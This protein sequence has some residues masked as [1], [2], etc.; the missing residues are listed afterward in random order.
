MQEQACYEEVARLGGYGM[1][2]TG[3][4]WGNI[5]FG[6]VWNIKNRFRNDKKAWN[7]K[8]SGLGKFG[9]A[10][11]GLG[12]KNNMFGMDKNVVT[13]LE[14]KNNRFGKVR[15]AGTG[16]EWKNGRRRHG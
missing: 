3:L 11:T 1:A 8:I 5:R 6:K 13:G 14:L 4:E 16:L 9:T 10:G 15:I 7:G 2:G 12:W